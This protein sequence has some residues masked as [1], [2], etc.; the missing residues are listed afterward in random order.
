MVALVKPGKGEN[1]EAVTWIDKTHILSL[2]IM[3]PAY[4]VAFRKDWIRLQSYDSL[5]GSNPH[6]KQWS[7]T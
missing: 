6:W 5:S 3:S 7:I 2:P 4:I 1:E